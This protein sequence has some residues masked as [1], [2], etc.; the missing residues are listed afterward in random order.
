MCRSNSRFAAAREEK[1]HRARAVML[2]VNAQD[3]NTTGR[4]GAVSRACRLAKGT[5]EVNL[6][7]VK[8]T[9][10]TGLFV[11]HLSLCSLR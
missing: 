11:A 6:D 2:K 3:P 9:F 4:A 1:T 8:V 7:Q 10:A 5:K